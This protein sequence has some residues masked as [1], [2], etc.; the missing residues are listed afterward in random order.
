MRI[1][2]THAMDYFISILV[3]VDE[4]KWIFSCFTLYKI[5]IA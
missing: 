5:R 1:A 3:N 2:Y 4:D